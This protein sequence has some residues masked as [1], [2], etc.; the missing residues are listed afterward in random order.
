[1]DD[2]LKDIPTFKTFDIFGLEVVAPL[3]IETA[4]QSIARLIE[5]SIKFIINPILSY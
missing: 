1:M 5:I 2:N 3:A 4:K